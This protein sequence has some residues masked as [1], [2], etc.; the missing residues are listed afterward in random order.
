M[1]FTLL[2]FERA[3]GTQSA[4][5]GG[6]RRGGDRIMSTHRAAAAEAEAEVAGSRLMIPFCL[7]H[8]YVRDA[9]MFACMQNGLK[10]F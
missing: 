5:R 7:I 9:P 2:H 6:Q 8:T 3:A 1:K 4:Y 10:N